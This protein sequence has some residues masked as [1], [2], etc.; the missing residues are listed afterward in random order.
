MKAATPG[1]RLSL[2]FVIV[3]TLLIV[4]IAAANDWSKPCF[5]GERMY[6]LLKHS[7]SGLG[8]LKIAGSPKSIALAPPFEAVKNLPG[9]L[10][11]AAHFEF[12]PKVEIA[13]VSF[14]GT[15]TLVDYNPK[16]CSGSGGPGGVIAGELQADIAGTGGGNARAGD[17]IDG[18]IVPPNIK[19]VAA[20]AGLSFDVDAQV[21]IKGA[22]FFIKPV[23]LPGFSIPGIPIGSMVELQGQAKAALDMKID[24]VVHL[25]YKVEDLELWYPA[26]RKNATEK[27]IRTKESPLKLKASA[28][29]E[30]KGYIEGHLIPVLKL[31]FDGFGTGVS[32]HLEADAF[33]R[34]SLEVEA[35]AT[36]KSC[37]RESTAPADPVHP[38]KGKREVYTPPYGRRACNELAL[39]DTDVDVH[40]SAKGGLSG[41]VWACFTAGTKSAS[42]RA[43]EIGPIDPQREIESASIEM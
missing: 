33:A 22:V 8:V 1:T 3:A 16:G 25:A 30:A 43:L 7:N 26:S 21:T 38:E 29:D 13:P 42:H 39:R 20:F 19:D 24:S 41:C 28:K 31:G 6:D 4:G 11:N 37:Y 17:I 32:V 35:H 5:N 14:N 18:S 9:L 2:Y 34:V 40:G 23:G 27:G 15:A 36:A 10:E 12:N